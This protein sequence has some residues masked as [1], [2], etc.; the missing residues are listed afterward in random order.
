MVCFEL[1]P[2]VSVFSTA[3]FEALAAY[4]GR[5][6]GI[7]MDP[8]HFWWQGI[9][10]ADRGRGLRRPHRLMP[11]ARDTLLYPDRIRKQGVLHYAPPSDPSRGALAFRLRSARAMTTRP[12]C[13][14]CARC[15]PAA[16]TA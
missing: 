10:P 7:N 8:S 1:H 5:N 6:I 12:G 16:M 15:A 14:S 11:T 3:G 13:G 9:D 4:V 2:G